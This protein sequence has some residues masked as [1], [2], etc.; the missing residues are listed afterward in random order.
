MVVLDVVQVTEL[1]SQG[2]QTILLH[3]VHKF[4]NLRSNNILIKAEIFVSVL[5]R[6]T[7]TKCAHREARIGISLPPINSVRLNYNS[8]CIPVAQSSS[9]ILNILLLKQSLARERN[10]S[11]LDAEFLLEHVAGLDS[12]GH[13]RT[14]TQQGNV[15]VFF[16]DKDVG[17]LGYV[18]A[19]RVLGVLLKVLTRQG[20]DCG[21][22]LGFQGSGECA[23]GFFCV[24]G[25][26]V[27]E[28]GHGAVEVCEGNGLMGR[29]VLAGAD[30]VVCGDVDGLKVLEGAHADGGGGVDVE[31]EKGGCDGEVGALVEAGET[32]GDGGH[33]VFADTVVNVATGVAA[34]DA[35]LGFE[36]GLQWSV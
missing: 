10:N 4:S 24:A 36:I 26:D 35:A 20:E 28:I 12:K 5:S 25:A 8:R 11:S 14:N 29:T 16:F 13:L 33:G 6:Q 15:G 21:C 27:E 3:V 23:G 22:V 2:I 19:R 31:H 17:A 30:G 32:V 1:A 9:L 18:I 34:I 7:L